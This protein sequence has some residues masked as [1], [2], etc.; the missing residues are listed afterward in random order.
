MSF[1]AAVS[2][3]GMAFKADYYADESESIDVWDSD[4][5]N[6][7]MWVVTHHTGQLTLRIYLTPDSEAVDEVEL[8]SATEVPPEPSAEPAPT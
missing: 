2:L 8:E 4:W 1:E 5:N 7:Y 6:H 3:E